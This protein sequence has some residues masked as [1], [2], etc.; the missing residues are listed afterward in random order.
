MPA[1]KKLQFRSRE[2]QTCMPPSGVLQPGWSGGV[3]KLALSWEE[4]QVE[5]AQEFAGLT[6]LGFELQ[7]E[8][9]LETR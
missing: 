2:I 3:A 8:A 6:V 9:V 1:L 4:V 5:V 7:K